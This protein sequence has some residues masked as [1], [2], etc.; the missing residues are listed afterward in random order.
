MKLKICW[1]KVDIVAHKR[2]T[3]E[4]A[5]IGKIGFLQPNLWS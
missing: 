5:V 3:I 2:N 1:P 4:L